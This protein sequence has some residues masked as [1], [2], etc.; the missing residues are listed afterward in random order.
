MDSV[1]TE[2]LNLSCLYGPHADR[3]STCILFTWMQARAGPLLKRV[4]KDT[5]PK[6]QTSCRSYSLLQPKPV[7]I[8]PKTLISNICVIAWEND[9][10]K[11]DNMLNWIASQPLGIWR[12]PY[13]ATYIYVYMYLYP[14]GPKVSQ[15]PPC[16]LTN[17]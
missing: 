9:G 12:V 13:I 8:H 11:A 15:A 2:A 14:D 4:P 17:L 6:P 10:V 5:Q 3:S 7:I 16:L 1:Q